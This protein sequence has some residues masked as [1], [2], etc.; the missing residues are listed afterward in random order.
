MMTVNEMI[1][2]VMAAGV[3]LGGIDCILGNRFGLGEKFEEGFLCLGPTALS[4]VGIICMSPLLAKLL[5]P[6]VIPLF[7]F[8]GADPAMFASVLAIDMGGYPLAMELAQNPEIGKFS[9]L[10]VASML[11]VAIVFL[12]PLGLE[13]IEKDDREYFAKGLL[14]GLV[15]IPAASFVGGILMGL[16]PLLVLKNLIP[17]IFIGVFLGAGMV[18]AQEQMVKGF[19]VFGRI[20]KVITVIG[21]SCGAVEY[22]TGIVLIPGMPPI[23]E[24][25]ETVAGICIVLLGSLPMLHLILKAL[26]KPFDAAGKWAGLDSQSVGGILFS[27]I[28]ALPVFRMMKDMCPKGKV[29]VTA[30][31]V[32]VI[33]VFSAHLA[34]VMAS[35]PK[36]LVPVMA[37]KLT[38]GV[39]AAVAVFFVYRQ[40]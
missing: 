33:S 39:M 40:R 17:V 14:I 28:S 24:A 23:M 36:V 31:M 25:M 12:I 34:Y 15:P 20:I 7:Q 16:P 11:G 38:G 30:V 13:M 6:V 35:E 9:G 8:L 22:M 32:N 21:L 1:M 3:L 37:A 4:M 27:C 5:G 29:M 26:K 10:V 18:F 19:L 2:Y